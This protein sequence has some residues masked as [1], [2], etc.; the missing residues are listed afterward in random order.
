MAK[1]IMVYPIKSVLAYGDT[2]SKESAKLLEELTAKTG[3][4]FKLV[5]LNELSKGD[6][7]LILVQSGG[8]EGFFKRD[9]FPVYKGPYYLLTYGSSN[10][11]AASLEIL[12][13]VKEQD[14]KG[15]VL[16]GDNSYIA[17]RLK[18]LIAE[19]KSSATPAARLGVVGE[20]S[21]WL[22]SSDVDHAKARDIFNIDL[23]DVKEEKILELIKK[24][25]E[26][27]PAGELK[28][29]FNPSELEK[30]YD[31]YEALKEL[32][33]EEQ[34]AGFTL[35]CFDII[36]A[37][38]M[39]ACLGLSLMNRDGIIASCEGD[40]PAMIT[41]YSILKCLGVHAFQANPNWI[42]P[43]KNELTLAHCTLP[44]DM[45]D[46]YQFDTHFESGIGVGI[47][48]VMKKGDVTI[49]KVGSSLNEFYC[50][51][52]TI[53]ENQYRKDRCRTQIVVA[54]NAPVTYF[55]KS[56]LGNHHQ[57]IYGHHKAELKAYFESLGLR[58]IEG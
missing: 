26:K 28:A 35:R 54:L 8:S 34:F 13:F 4:E 55:L 38:K 18:T 43:V 23:V 17:E 11:L 36:K 40:V 31:I 33:T 51:E 58:E 3:Y 57:V 30:A 19:K 6:L 29:E 53:L 25:H 21:D 44:L 10:S 37:V 5:G 20:P 14:K 48:G 46:T 47:H 32:C 22:I 9:I 7:P 52:G 56:S 39:S 24:H 27:V 50:E 42:D 12:S 45:A 16:H 41:A 1:T 2:I 49:V 15:E